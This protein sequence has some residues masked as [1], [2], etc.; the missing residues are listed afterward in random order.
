MKFISRSLL[1]LLL[2]YGL[3]FAFGDVLLLRG[4]ASLWMWIGFPVVLIGLQYL[5]SPWLIEMFLSIGW[6]YEGDIPAECREFVDKL[7][8]ERGIPRPKIGYIFSGTPNAFSYGRLRSDAKVVV[9]EGLVKVLTPDE[10]NS[11]LAHEIGHIE[12]YDFA[13]MAV[14]SLAPML[15]YQIY[16]WCRHNSNTRQVAWGAY[17]C[18]LLSQYVVLLLNRTREYWADHYSAEVTH[19]PE[20]LSSALIKI[21]YGMIRADGEYRE[22]LQKGSKSEKSALRKEHRLGQTVA[23]MGISNLNAGQSLALSGTDPRGA[24]AIM[25]WD[26]LNPWARVYELSSTHPLTALRV[27]AMNEE[28]RKMHLPV[29]YPLPLDEPKDWGRFATELAIWLAPWLPLALFVTSEW[30]PRTMAHFGLVM[31]GPSKAILLGMTGLLFL[32]RTL[33]RYRGEFQDSTIGPLLENLEVSQMQPKAVRLRGEIVG[34]GVPGAFWSADLVLRDA[35]GMIFMLYRQSIPF[36][37]LLFAVSS[38]DSLE[39]QQVTIEGW[40]RRGLRPYV[41]MS[42]L[43]DEDGKTHRAW[44]RWV[45]IGVEVAAIAL[46]AFW[47]YSVR[48]G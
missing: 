28:A 25:R 10:L 21:A 15:L 1:I 39:G 33:F 4:H 18:Y 7:C 5:V 2:L 12:H 31:D 29:D 9:T 11:V 17:L 36:A 37:R 47:W 46:G 40:F 34:R 30:L 45:Q 48:L 23:I 19:Q 13:V 32:V 44:S 6:D 43:T 3:V 38:V 42:Q 27:R 20:M 35:T 26:I 16:A 22:S 24:A 8:A 41:E 14:A